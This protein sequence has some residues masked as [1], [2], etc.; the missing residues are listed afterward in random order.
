MRLASQY[1]EAEWTIVNEEESENS[2]YEE[3]EDEPEFWC[4]VC[5]KIFKSEKSL[6]NHEK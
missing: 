6:N 5:D 3:E 4:V 2:D 1:Q